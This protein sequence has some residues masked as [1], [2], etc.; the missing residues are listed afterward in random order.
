MEG[1]AQRYRMSR[2]EMEPHEALNEHLLETG[3]MDRLYKY[4]LREK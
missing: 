2:G 1:A 4:W 3:L